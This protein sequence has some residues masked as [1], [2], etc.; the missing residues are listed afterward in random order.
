MLYFDLGDYIL[1]RSNPALEFHIPVGFLGIS[2]KGVGIDR[3]HA[4]FNELQNVFYWTSPQMWTDLKGDNGQRDKASF[5]LMDTYN[6]LLSL[7]VYY[8]ITGMR[9]RI[10]E[11]RRVTE[12]LYMIY[13]IGHLEGEKEPKIY[14][15]PASL[16]FTNVVDGRESTNAVFYHNGQPAVGI[17]KH[18]RKY[19]SVTQEPTEI[20]KI[21]RALVERFGKILSG[22]E[23]KVNQHNGNESAPDCEVVLVKPARGLGLE[24][25]LP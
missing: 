20:G 4:K 8:Q 12:G 14:R 19:P 25:R 9:G 5:A 24:A 3:F 10:V 6:A 2:S 22:I 1:G 11:P 18:Q 7:F 21:N 17:A 16:I 13:L 23:I 15:V